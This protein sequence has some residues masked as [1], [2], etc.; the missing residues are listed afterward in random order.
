MHDT[1]IRPGFDFIQ[2]FADGGSGGEGGTGA[3][4]AAQAANGQTEAAPAQPQNKGAK[5]PLANVQY[6]TEAGPAAAGQEKIAED[7]ATQFDALIKGEY[8]DLYEA[9]LKDTMAKRLK[10]TEEI[11]TKYNSISSTFDLLGRKYGL[12]PK[13]P[14][15]AEKLV[16]EIEKDETFYEDEALEKGLTVQQVKEMRAM[17]RENEQLREQVKQRES[18]EAADRTYAAWM[19]DAAKVKEIYPSFD[20]RAELQNPQM[21]R[22][23]LS[24]VDMRTAYEVIHKDELIGGAMQFTAGKIAQKVANSVAAGRTRPAE[25]A[26]GNQAPVISK[27]DVSQLTKADRLEIIRRAERGAQIGFD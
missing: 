18:K 2:L 23:L 15:F 1:F 7:R 8:K 9:K 27:R 6:G 11:V 14:D 13:A 19:E 4:T 26:M 16:Q 20:I 3:G 24:N 25:G 5:N 17:Q 10:G 12:D 21:Q 22:L